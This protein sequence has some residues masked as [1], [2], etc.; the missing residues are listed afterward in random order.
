MMTK[1]TKI[2]FSVQQQQQQ[3]LS[4]K[5]PPWKVD[6]SKYWGVFDADRFKTNGI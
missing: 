2:Y 3:Q 4:Q 1:K 6:V 5:S